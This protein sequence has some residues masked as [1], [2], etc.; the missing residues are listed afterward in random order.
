MERSSQKLTALGSAEDMFKKFSFEVAKQQIQ[1]EAY[2]PQDVITNSRG[3]L[4]NIIE[5]LVQD[6]RWRSAYDAAN[7]R[8]RFLYSPDNRKHM[9]EEIEP[10]DRLSARRGIGKPLADTFDNCDGVWSWSDNIK[11]TL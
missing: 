1:S 3:L 7:V 4:R 11:N 6:R 2:D 9:I 8:N 5:N 10:I